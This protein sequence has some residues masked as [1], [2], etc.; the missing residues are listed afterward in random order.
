MKYTDML[1][2]QNIYVKNTSEENKGVARVFLLVGIL[3]F[4]GVLFFF[5]KE[6]IKKAFNPIKIVGGSSQSK[7]NLKQSDGRTN[8]LILGSDK[9]DLGIE[10]GRNTL[11]DT[12]LVASIGNIDNDVVLISL[13]RDLWVTNYKL[14][15]GYM[16]SSKINEIYANASIEELKIQMENILGIPIHYYATVTFQLFEEIIDTLEGVE[17]NVERTFTDY[18]YPI[19]G[20][21]SDLCGKT[22]EETEDITKK[23]LENGG[24]YTEDGKTINFLTAFPCRYETVSF[25]QGVQKMDG[26]T[27]LKY[28]RS[29][30][31]NNGEGSDFAR[32]KRQQGVIMAIKNKALSVNTLLNP[33][34]IKELYTQ[35]VSN[36]ETDI[37]LQDLQ[38]F[39]QLS[40]DLSFEDVKSIVVD[41]G[42]NA[43]EGGLLYHPTDATLYKGAWVLVPQAGDFSQIHAYVQKYL[44]GNK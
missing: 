19:E 1:K 14:K 17:I 18:E 8:I 35:Y 2:Q 43:D 24:S 33:I 37:E 34:K 12:I 41:T 13:P 7:L 31:G 11:T 27:A 21:E 10:S 42:D 5:F 25:D 32:S 22:E 15:N 36:V 9:R 4:I 29:R 23:I 26:K 39:Y 20:K 28:A 30:H 40:Q 6:P 3:I 16:Y 44:F 38:S